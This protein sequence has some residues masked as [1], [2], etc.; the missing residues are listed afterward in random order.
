[1]TSLAGGIIS[2]FETISKGLD[3]DFELLFNQPSCSWRV[4]LGILA[5]A[6]V[7]SGMWQ[8][9][10]QTKFLGHESPVLLQALESSD[11]ISKHFA[12]R[13]DEPI[14]LVSMRGGMNAG[15]ATVLNPVHKLIE[16]HL[17]P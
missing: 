1:M 4:V 6:R 17:C 10:A 12:I 2:S 14:E 16:R 7:G 13:I 11:E 5:G 15:A 3:I 9:L 8:G